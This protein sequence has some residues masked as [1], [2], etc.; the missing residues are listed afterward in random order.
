MS[1]E[2]VIEY[3]SPTLA[4]LK[5]GNLFSAK[6]D[7]SRD[8]MN[9]I[10]NLDSMLAKKGVRVIPVKTSKN[11]VLVYVYRPD[12]LERDLKV[13]EALAILRDKGYVCGEDSDYLDQLIRHLQCDK[14][15]PHEIG[16]FLGYPPS[17]VRGFMNSPCD[18]VKCCGYW[19]VYSDMDSALRT[20]DRYRRCTEVYREAYKKGRSIVQL[21]VK[22]GK[23]RK[24]GN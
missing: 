10:E 20:F 13:P 22:T 18:G 2:H 11:R 17:D 4:G 1:E 16:L 19:K 9:R 7:Q 14:T 6:Y 3:C 5:T 24:R 15:F 8:I 23:K 12:F 21:A